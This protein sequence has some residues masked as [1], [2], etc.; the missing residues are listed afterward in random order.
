MND[1][2]T[3]MNDSTGFFRFA[4]NMVDG[5]NELGGKIKSCEHLGTGIGAATGAVGGWRFGIHRAEKIIARH[6]DWDENTKKWTK[7]SI[8][9]CYTGGGLCVGGLVGSRLDAALRH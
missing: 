6:P 5:F 8:I 9:I 1:L 7:G 4:G 2:I 3:G